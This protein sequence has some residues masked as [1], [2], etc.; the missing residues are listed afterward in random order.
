MTPHAAVLA[1]LSPE[2]GRVRLGE[3][4]DPGPP[5]AGQVRVRMLRAPINP[6]DL[7]VIDRAYS[8]A[9]DPADPLGA[10]GVGEVEAVG[11]GVTDLHPGDR[12]LPLRRGTWCARRLLP[13]TAL[14]ALPANVDPALAAMLRINPPTAWLLLKASGAGPGDVL[15]QN[16]ATSAVAAWVRHF[17]PALGVTVIDVARRADP[18]LPDALIDGPDV[19]GRIHAAA[20]GR[21]I[22]AALDCVAGEATGR[23]AAALGTGGRLILFGHLSGQPIRVVSQLITGGGLSIGGFSL[24]PAEAALGAAGVARLF[25]DILAAVAASTPDLPVRATLPLARAE[26]AVALARDGGRGRVQLLC[27]A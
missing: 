10:E 12:V 6:A 9:L 19:A 5:G 21:P 15:V 13:R 8:I 4:P 17:A 25:G 22:R 20:G 24:R 26:E 7:L 3:L 14:V 23:L 1:V 18:G 27:D 16:G 2:Q 11:E